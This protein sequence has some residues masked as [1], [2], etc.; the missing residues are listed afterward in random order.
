MSI[1]LRPPSA[2][3]TPKSIVFGVALRRGSYSS[4]S[5]GRRSLRTSTAAQ[6]SFASLITG[7]KSLDFRQRETAASKRCA[8]AL[9]SENRLSLARRGSNSALTLAIHSS[10]AAFQSMTIDGSHARRLARSFGVTRGDSRA[11]RTD[12]VKLTHS[13]V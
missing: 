9:A 13:T 3:S 6:S 2:H 11:V 7:R 5:V 12:D 8:M 1:Q 10:L 4:R